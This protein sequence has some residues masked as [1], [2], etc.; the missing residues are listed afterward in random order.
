MAL[1]RDAGV[2]R[3]TIVAGYK[4]AA[5]PRS[6]AT[7]ATFA[8]SINA[9]FDTTGSMASL[10]IAHRCDPRS[11]RSRYRK[12]HHLR[13]ARADRVAVRFG[14]RDADVGPNRRRRRGLGLGIRQQLRAMS[15]RREDRN[16]S[17]A[18]SSAS[19]VFRRLLLPPCIR[20]FNDS[21]SRTVIAG[22]IRDRRAGRASRDT[23]P[24]M[25]TLIPD[26]CW[27]EIDDEQ[28]YRRVVNRVAELTIGSADHRQRVQ[29]KPPPAIVPCSDLIVFFLS[30]ARSLCWPAQPHPADGCRHDRRLR[31]DAERHDPPRRRAGRAAQFL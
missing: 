25:T 3:I 24:I 7:R 30:F 15:K 19:R 20:F 11:R 23:I 2:T 29:M 26:L 12:R 9:A 4:A 10:A 8:S 21:S 18:S 6:R 28:Q 17:R 13:I 1:L 14:Q 5:Y 31:D 16:T 27:G 22:W